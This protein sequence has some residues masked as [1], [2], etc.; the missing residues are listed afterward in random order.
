[1][2]AEGVEPTTPRLQ[3]TCSGQLSYIG[4]VLTIFS[5]GLRRYNFLRF[6]LHLV[7]NF[8]RFFCR[9][10]REASVGLA[11]SL[12]DF[13]EHGL[14]SYPYASFAVHRLIYNNILEGLGML[15]YMK[16]TIYVA[17]E[18]SVEFPF[19][20]VYALCKIILILHQKSGLDGPWIDLHEVN[21]FT[22]TWLRM[23]IQLM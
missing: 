21:I 19:H 12:D 3:I 23:Q 20:I 16:D 10:R 15:C 11:V 6:A 17:L 9:Y 7:D 2:G 4:N 14:G 18:V 5:K 13:L 8:L 22:I 1:M